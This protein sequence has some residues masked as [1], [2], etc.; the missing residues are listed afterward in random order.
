MLIAS[1]RYF[2][3]TKVLVRG[4]CIIVSLYILAI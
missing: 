1:V 2:V 4:I 3:H